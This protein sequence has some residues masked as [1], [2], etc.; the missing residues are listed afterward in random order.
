MEPSLKPICI[1]SYNSTGFGLG[2]VRFMETLLVFSNILCVQE[3]FLQ[4]SGDKNIVIPIDLENPSQIMTCLLTLLIKLTT[5][6][7]RVELKEV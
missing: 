1:T 3:H 2:A 7:V 6:F 5:E 4:D